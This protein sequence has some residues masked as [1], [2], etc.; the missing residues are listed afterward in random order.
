LFHS[1]QF[2]NAVFLFAFRDKERGEAKELRAYNENKKQL[3]EERARGKGRMADEDDDQRAQG[4]DEELDA[5]WARVREFL[6][7]LKPNGDKKE[8]R[9]AEKAN[10]LK[11]NEAFAAY[12]PAQSGVIAK[13]LV[14]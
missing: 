4:A 2:I 10:K 13:H 9:G 6:G 12:D 3:K 5:L 7:D 14:V 8:R 11:L 1:C